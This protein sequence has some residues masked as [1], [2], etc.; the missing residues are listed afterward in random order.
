[1]RLRAGAKLR[2][3]LAREIALVRPRVL[4]LVGRLAVARF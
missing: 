1:L 2:R 4:L 3:W